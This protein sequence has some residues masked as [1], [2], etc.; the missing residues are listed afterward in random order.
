MLQKTEEAIKN[1]QSEQLEASGTQDTERRQTRQNK[2]TTLKTETMSKTD[3]PKPGMNPGAL[4][5]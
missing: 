1:G 4:D 2:N 5:G 3:P